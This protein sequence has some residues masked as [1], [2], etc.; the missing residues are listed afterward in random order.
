MWMHLVW[1]DGK[2]GG[3]HLCV[4]VWRY[5]GGILCDKLDMHTFDEL[6]NDDGVYEDD[7]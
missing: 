2:Y 1:N 6:S 4:R 7:F 3:S 5:Q